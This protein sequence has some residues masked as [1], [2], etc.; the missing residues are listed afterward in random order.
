L[1]PLVKWHGGKNYLARRFVAL[2]PRHD[3][4]VEPFAG[5]L[6]VMLAKP[7]G[8][9]EVAADINPGL[10]NLYRVL[11]ADTGGF[12]AFVRRL[13]YDR[14]AF[15]RAAGWVDQRDDRMLWAAGFLVR[16]RFSRGGLGKTF[17]WSER[18]RGGQPGD[19]NAWQ[20][21]VESLDAIADR[22]ASVV[23]L[24][25]DGL[26]VIRE[27]DS[28]G[29]LFYCDPPYLHATRTAKGAYAHEMT[30]GQHAALLDV[31]LACR[32]M[33]FLSGYHNPLYD[34]R[35]AG[36]TLHEFERPNDAGQG[37]TKQRRIECLWSNVPGPPR[38]ALLF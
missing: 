2:F 24:E 23:F 33:V 38:Q 1:R 18:L 30:D 7:R 32:G 4:Y 13:A 9:V 19:L 3:T 20:G 15:D 12:R 36:W 5:S 31:L 29:T 6:A 28:P 25:R 22:L 14:E 8:R 11:V 37:R 35:L 34:A 16:T 10:V 26:G 27:L 17:A 21:L